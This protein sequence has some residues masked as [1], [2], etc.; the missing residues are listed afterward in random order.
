MPN[1]PN[2][3]HRLSR[4]FQSYDAPVYFVTFCTADRKSILA[5]PAV[6]KSFQQYALKAQQKQTAR[7]MISNGLGISLIVECT[8]LSAEEIAELTE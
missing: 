4:I 6:H 8:G 5:N 3:P 1:P 2:K 7:K